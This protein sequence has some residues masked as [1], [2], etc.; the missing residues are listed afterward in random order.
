[1]EGKHARAAGM[2]VCLCVC[3]E[4]K[5]ARGG[6]QRGATGRSAAP[7]RD[8]HT[9]TPQSARARQAAAPTAPRTGAEAAR[10]AGERKRKGVHEVAIAGRTRALPRDDN[11]S[12][13]GRRRGECCAPACPAA[14]VPAA[15]IAS[16]AAKRRQDKGDDDGTP[17]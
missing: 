8:T 4:G 17:Q 16:G 9:H 7:L 11:L 12:L 3:M 6:L 10:R 15:S 1:M 13:R 5:H 2:Y 14:C